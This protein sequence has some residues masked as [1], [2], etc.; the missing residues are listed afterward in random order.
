M[1]IR[2][3]TE[4]TEK[5]C[6]KEIDKTHAKDVKEAAVIV[7]ILEGK[8]GELGLLRKKVAGAILQKVMK[9]VGESNKEVLLAQ[10]KIITQEGTEAFVSWNDYVLVLYVPDHMIIGAKARKMEGSGLH[11]LKKRFKATKVE[12]MDKIGDE[13]K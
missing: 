8:S 4:M 5:E 11:K 9:I 13:G 3:E 7:K 12:Y 1:R 10:M 6:I 2:I